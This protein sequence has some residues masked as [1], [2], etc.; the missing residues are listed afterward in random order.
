MTSLSRLTK[1]DAGANWVQTYGYDGFGNLTSK[2]T[3][4]GSGETTMPSMLSAKNRLGSA[5]YDLNGNVT[6]VDTGTYSYDVENRLVGSNYA[7]LG[8][9]YDEANRRVEDGGL[10]FYSP[11]GQL[12]ATFQENLGATP[13]T[14]LLTARIY[15]GG[16]IVGEIGNT[17]SA[18][19]YSK[20]LT[21]RLGSTNPTL[22]YGGNLTALSAQYQKEFAT[23]PKGPGN[24][25][26]PMQRYYASG[27]G[28]FM[29]ADPAA[30]GNPSEPG[31][32]NFYAYVQGDPINLNDPEG[33]DVNV[34]LD[35]LAPDRCGVAVANK[36]LR[37]TS[38]GVTAQGAHDLFNSKEGILALSLF[39]EV[40]PNGAYYD[41]DSGWYQ[42]M[43]GVAN[44]YLNRYYVN[45]G[46]SHDRGTEGFKQAIM[47]A[48]TPIWNR[49]KRG[50]YTSRGLRSD[51]EKSLN[52]ILRGP[53]NDLRGTARG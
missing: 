43:L 39:Y 6:A 31:S 7:S 38:Y 8:I 33:L 17:G 10:Y 35:K 41:E 23:Y 20:V 24:L 3:P 32:W 1:A 19:G 4:P 52:R 37:T 49:T 2:S 11:D 16:M 45:W 26:Y 46:G 27:V 25:G 21:D 36:I 28:R 18:N 15:F 53:A 42:A 40:R 51:Y 30:P 13:T 5:S 14:H 34:R 44:V 48:S 47:D 50:N 29:T 22:P 12:L 9:S